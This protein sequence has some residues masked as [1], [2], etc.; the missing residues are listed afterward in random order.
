MDYLRVDR[1]PGTTW[2]HA[3]DAKMLSEHERSRGPQSYVSIDPDSGKQDCLL[4]PLSRINVFIG[5]NNAG[6][7]RLLRWMYAQNL[8]GYRAGPIFSEAAA[9]FERL[10]NKHARLYRPNTGESQGQKLMNMYFGHEGLFATARARLYRT[11]ISTGRDTLTPCRSLFES[12]YF[13]EQSSSNKE[14][15]GW[16]RDALR[17]DDADLGSEI[18]PHQPLARKVFV[19][20]RRGSLMALVRGHVPDATSTVRTSDT[21]YVNRDIAAAMQ[22][23]INLGEI[24]R[25]GA[26]STVEGIWTGDQ[27]R[28]TVFRCEHGQLE[29][30]EFKSRYEEFLSR[31]VYRGRRVKLITREPDKAGSEVPHFFKSLHVQI[32]G[33]PERPLYS[34]GDGIDQIIIMTLPMFLFQEKIQGEEG[35]KPL[36]LFVDEPEIHLH[37]TFQRLLIEAWLDKINHPNFQVF[38]TTHSTVFLD[39]TIAEKGIAAFSVRIGEYDSKESFI[40]RRVLQ[41]AGDV[42][43][44]LGVRPSQVLLTN[45]TIWVEG[46]SDRIYLRGYL[47]CLVQELNERAEGMPQVSPGV[48]FDPREDVHY[49]VVP[50]GGSNLASFE[51]DPAETESGS[52]AVKSLCAKPFLIA[53]RDSGKNEKHEKLRKLLDGRYLAI[54]AIEIENTLPGTALLRGICD[55]RAWRDEWLE[56]AVAI[57]EWAKYND[58]RMGAYLQDRAGLLTSLGVKLAGSHLPDS[59]KAAGDGKGVTI[60]AK[61]PFARKAV[62]ALTSWND[63]PRPARLLAVEVYQHIAR[64]NEREDAVEL[65]QAVKDAIGAG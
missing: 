8:A 30:R 21:V 2:P 29:R 58:V 10:Y 6:K 44:D 63:L 5:P 56:H 25:Q 54:E 43:R 22:L 52:T 27:L 31:N 61:V 62:K 49:S 7:S 35:T 47:D 33:H 37:P 26:T 1:G 38:L 19:P 4:G 14:S 42:L 23:G 53:D 18:T 28:E 15:F 24:T 59:A 11:I 46:E 41:D 20:Q 12:M 60:R 32:D 50:Y 17:A 34:L 45:C 55:E 3:E 51:F 57:D 64:Y 16:L 40:V 48:V 39:A 65:A 13:R 9:E 36:L